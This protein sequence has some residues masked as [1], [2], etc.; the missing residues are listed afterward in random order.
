MGYT[1]GGNG[2][3]FFIAN[4]SKISAVR[5]VINRETEVGANL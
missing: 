5:D 4:S 3:L 2:Y 1:E